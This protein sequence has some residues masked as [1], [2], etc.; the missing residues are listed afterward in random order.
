LSAS[1]HSRGIASARDHR[2]DGPNAG[3]TLTIKL[4]H[5]G[6]ADHPEKYDALIERNHKLQESNLAGHT[7]VPTFVFYQEPFFGQDRMDQLWC[8]LNSMDSQNANSRHPTNGDTLKA[9][10]HSPTASRMSTLGH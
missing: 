8:A 3:H 5:S 1:C 4:D 10:P 6:G 9:D 7:G 2:P